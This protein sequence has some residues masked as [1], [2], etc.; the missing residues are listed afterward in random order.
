METPKPTREEIA[1]WIKVWETHRRI[2][3]TSSQP[4]SRK[5]IVKWLRN[6]YS[7]ACEYKMWGNGVSLP[8]VVF[9]LDGIANSK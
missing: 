4:K 2:N 7:D 1:F 5:Q 9:V 3:D 6:P 8:V